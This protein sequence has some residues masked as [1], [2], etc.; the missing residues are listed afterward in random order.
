MSL[1]ISLVH[2]LKLRMIAKSVE[3]Q[4]QLDYLHQRHCDEYRAAFSVG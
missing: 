4:A 3:T 2:S 1:I